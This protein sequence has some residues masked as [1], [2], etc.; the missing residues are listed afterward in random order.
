LVRYAVR[1]AVALVTLV[2]LYLTSVN[3]IVPFF[4]LHY[5]NYPKLTDAPKT[6]L[7]A[8][9]AASDPLNLA[10]LG[11]EEEVVMALLQAGWSPSDPATFQ[12]SNRYPAARKVLSAR[13]YPRVTLA[14]LFLFGRRQ[15]LRFEKNQGKTGRHVVRYW[16]SNE[17]GSPSRPLWVGSAVLDRSPDAAGHRIAP[18]LDAEREALVDDLSRVLRLVEVSR[19]TGVGPTLSGLTGEGNSYVTD[20]EIAVGVLPVGGAHDS[21]PELVASPWTVRI[22]DRIWSELRPLIGESDEP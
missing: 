7:T 19:V 16:R 10:L 1:G 17:L 18:D 11:S 6:A 14:D 2:V 21:P 12:N 5:E 9:N 15:D 20:G 3:F 4:W 22:K 8:G 13:P